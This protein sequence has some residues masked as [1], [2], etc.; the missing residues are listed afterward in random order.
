VLTISGLGRSERVRDE[1]READTEETRHFRRLEIIRV[2]QKGR[3][4]RRV[5]SSMFSHE[6]DQF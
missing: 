1:R 6:A 2:L 3:V 5:D 4:L